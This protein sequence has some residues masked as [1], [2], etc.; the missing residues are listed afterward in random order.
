MITPPFFA[1]RMDNTECTRGTGCSVQQGVDSLGV[2]TLPGSDTAGWTRVFS[3]VFW[4]RPCNTTPMTGVDTDLGVDPGC[5]EAVVLGV[6][7]F[8]SWICFPIC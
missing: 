5:Q 4:V 6:E 3:G 2:E 7:M 8:S 1:C